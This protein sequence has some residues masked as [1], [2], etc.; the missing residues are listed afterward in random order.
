MFQTVLACTLGAIVFFSRTILL[1]GNKIPIVSS[2]S[3]RKKSLISRSI[4][5]LCVAGSSLMLPRIASSN[6]YDGLWYD[7]KHQ[8]IFD[9]LRN[10]FV[11]AFPDIFLK[12]ELKS[13]KVVII[14]EVHSNPCHHRL[15]F[16]IIKA[17]A[18][19][20]QK[21]PT[22]A[23]GLEAFYRQHQA[24]LDRYVFIHKDF[25]KLQDETNWRE[26]W[27]FDLNF[28]AKIFN[29]A[30]QHGIRLV[31]LNC[32]YPLVKLV[33]QYGLQN[34]PDNLKP[35]LPSIDLVSRHRLNFNFCFAN[36]TMSFSM[37]SP[38][39]SIE[40]SLNLQLDHLRLTARRNHSVACMNRKHYGKNIWQNL[41]LNLLPLIPHA[42]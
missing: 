36:F 15:E 29:F 28:Y 11:P 38:T 27:G 40:N 16:E 4:G 14:G 23:I 20:N 42:R 2:I 8:R 17:L 18:K 32:P 37:C 30:A 34:I 22:V 35:F 3:A 10:S 21:V 5:Q 19:D 25:Q 33:S 9:T 12:K 13:K 26:V 1:L 39:K 41:H 24:A 31:G 6:D 7:P